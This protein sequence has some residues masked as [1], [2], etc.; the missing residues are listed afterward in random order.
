MSRPLSERAAAGTSSGR[1]P[2]NEDAILLAQLSP[3]AELIAVADGMGGYQAGEI[4]SRRALE[5]LHSA[6]MAGEALPAAVRL[7]NDAVFDEASAR[8]ECRGMGTTLVAALRQGNHYAVVNVGDSRAFRIDRQ[9]ISQITCD[10]SFVAE[11]VQS[12]QLSVKEAER[13]LWRNA[14]TRCVG[15]DRELEVDCYG[16]YDPREPH[17]LVLCTDG[18]H[19]ALSPDTLRRLVLE[20]VDPEAAVSAV[21]HAAYDAGSDDNISVAV[22]GFEPLVLE[23]PPRSGTGPPVI[24]PLRESRR[25]RSSHRSR[26]RWT[27]VHAAVI[28]LGAILAVAYIARGVLTP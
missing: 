5:V 15:T 11:A 8:P 3:A 17:T 25:R 28:L 4:A 23:S 6:V 9:G 18:A 14:V 27:L 2:V 26:G 12:G 22:V 24:A 13:S 1:R 19:R 10:N 20:A 7:A 16:P 21:L